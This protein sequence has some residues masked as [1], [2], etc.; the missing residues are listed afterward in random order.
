MRFSMSTVKSYF[1]ERTKL[2][3]VIEVNRDDLILTEETEE[4]AFDN[5]EKRRP[6]MVFL[7]DICNICLVWKF[8]N[9]HIGL[10]A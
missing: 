5:C 8:V 3:R 4:T 9:N 6:K 10:V 7:G 1:F 2:G